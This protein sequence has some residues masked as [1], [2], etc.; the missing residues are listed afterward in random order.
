M[1]YEE[2]RKTITPGRYRHFKGKEYEVIAV[3]LAVTEMPVLGVNDDVLNEVIAEALPATDTPVIGV[4]EL[5]TNDVIAVDVEN[6]A[7]LEALTTELP[8]TVTSCTALGSLPTMSYVTPSREICCII[9]FG[10]FIYFPFCYV[11]ETILFLYVTQLVA[12][13]YVAYNEDGTKTEP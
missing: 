13:I 12:A 8:S 7:I 5:Y 9:S 6:T 1:R 10:I 2:A 3:A 11:I 4:I